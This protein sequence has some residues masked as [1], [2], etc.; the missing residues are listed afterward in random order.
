MKLHIFGTCSGTEPFPGRHH[1]S[2][3]VDWQDR[4]YWFDAGECC[5]HTAHVMGINIQRTA[6]ICIS[7][8]HLDHVGGLANLLWTLRK[9]DGINRG[10]RSRDIDLYIP[11]IRCWQGISAMLKGCQGGFVPDFTVSAR[12]YGDG[13][14]FR[15]DGLTVTALH[16]NHLSHTEGEPWR[17]F[18]F[19][20]QAGGSTVVYSGDT[21]GIDDFAP[22]LPCDLLLME[23][24]HHHPAGIARELLL[25]GLPFGRLAFIHHGRRILDEPDAQISALDALPGLDYIILDDGMT[26][27][28][29]RR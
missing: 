4:L 7:H 26:I 28:P 20:I 5:S 6:K 29:D 1:C 2:F 25:R 14:L 13:V 9:L 12:E 21:G 3:A 17:A 15:E 8:T 22:L 11:D 24:G 18:G 27:M 23:T 19:K 16:T 10:Q